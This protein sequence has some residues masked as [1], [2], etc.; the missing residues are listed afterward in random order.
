M[1]RFVAPTVTLALIVQTMIGHA[2]GADKLTLTLR[3]TS[4]PTGKVVRVSDIADIRGGD[5]SLRKRVADLDIE[6]T[7]L[8][9]EQIEIT[10]EQLVFR[11]RLAGIRASA[12]EVRGSVV[13]VGTRDATGSGEHLSEVARSVSRT[14]VPS[15][16]Q[17]QSRPSETSSMADT[18]DQESTTDCQIISAAQKCV[19]KRLPWPEEDV[20]FQV[21]QPQPRE[22]DQLGSLR[23]QKLSAEL[24]ST[25]APIGRASVRVLVTTAD[26]R[27]VEVP[28]VLDV[29]H[30]DHVVLAAKGIQRGQ[31][32]TAEHLFVDRRDVSQLSNYCATSAELVG[33]RA[34]RT[35]SSLQ[36]LRL[37]DV[38]NAS[39]SPASNPV[40]VKR[41]DRLKVIGRSGI[42]AVTITGEALQDGRAGEVIQVKNV[43]S[44]S[45]LR[46]RV[47][48]ASEVEV[49]E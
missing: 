38:E 28:V 11:L 31:I 27:S 42:L 7:P 34:K 10:S 39:T 5:T 35:I 21:I 43:N 19:L 16:K 33:R 14:A 29:K 46:G 23:I 3:P 36:P 12:V 9:G 2:M 49:Q 18:F 24:R 26:Q 20:E 1:S 47:I 4:I 15:D 6:E 41:R 48:N 8:V 44:N 37:A 40:L 30:F 45:V 17:S 25:G 32:I 13:R 22:I